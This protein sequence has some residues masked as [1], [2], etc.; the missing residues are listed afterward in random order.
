MSFGSP[1]LLLFLL[2]IPAAVLLL[3]LLERRRDRRAAV[4][5]APALLPNIASRPAPW[6]RWLPIS[7][8]LLGTTLLLVG[9]ARPRAG[10]T[11]GRNEATLVVV[12]D[13]SGS[14]AA[15]DVQ[16]TRLEAAK[17]D[18]RELL[19][20]T[21]SEYRVAVVAFSDHSAVVVPPTRDRSVVDGALAR[22]HSGPEGTALTDALLR[23]LLLGHSLPKIDGKRPPAS[24]LVLSD[25]AANSGQVTQ[26]QVLAAAKQ[27]GTPISA[28]VIG[29]PS[30]VVHQKLQGGYIEQI[31]VPVATQLLDA[32]AQ[33]S[34]GRAYPPTASLTGV[35][36]ELGTRTG[37]EHKTVEVT[38]GAAAGGLAFM[39][40]G[41]LLS[42]VWFRRI[43]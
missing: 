9:F 17:R 38:V 29:T 35:V 24:V 36:H 31:A 18:V 5:A 19:A 28:V 3:L 39:V 14:M 8:L 42:G 15:Q 2:A 7:L 4:W 22:L 40:L 43:P 33:G 10:I 21:P 37:Q 27:D 30:G 16:P 41:G 13:I 1:Y 12:L 6:R 26:Q 32:V 20:D 11:V 23:A 25:G 34:G